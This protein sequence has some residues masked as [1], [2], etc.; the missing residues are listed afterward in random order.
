MSVVVHAVQGMRSSTV[1]NNDLAR[2]IATV[3]ER[4]AAEQMPRT[5]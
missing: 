3:G 5:R 1:I 2:A 4:L